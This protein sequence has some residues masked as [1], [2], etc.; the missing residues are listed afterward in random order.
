MKKVTRCCGIFVASRGTRQ[1]LALPATTTCAVHRYLPLHAILPGRYRIANDRLSDR[2]SHP[3]SIQHGG[4]RMLLPLPHASPDAS[5]PK[6]EGE[7]VDPEEPTRP[8]PAQAPCEYG[9]DVLSRAK[10]PHL[11]ARTHGHHF[12]LIFRRAI[13]A[14][15]LSAI[16]PSHPLPTLH[17]FLKTLK[18]ARCC[19]A[20][21]YV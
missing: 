6:G 13:H 9:P 16:P 3:P 12:S 21:D 8:P 14:R 1:W 20:H 18:S 7:A 15:S 11:D 10:A 19:P 17:T 5:T 2:F 4:S